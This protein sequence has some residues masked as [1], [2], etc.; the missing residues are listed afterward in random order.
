MAGSSV[1]RLVPVVMV[2]L[3][4]VGVVPTAVSAAA[5][6]PPALSVG[7]ASLVEGNSGSPVLR[8][9]V[10]LA[11]PAPG[12]VAVAYVTAPGTATAGRDYTSRQGTLKFAAGSTSAVVSVP[13]LPD[14]V[15]EPNETLTLRLSGATG[16]TVTRVVGTGRILDDDPVP[17]RQVGVGDVTVV[18]GATGTR[19]A[20]F[21]VTL[22][23]PKTSA[24]TVHYAT[25]DG[26]AVAGQDFTAVSG[27]LTIAAGQTSGDISV[28]ILGDV[29]AEPDE[30][31]DLV[32]SAP[33]G[34]A[35]GRSSAHG[36]IRNDDG[37]QSAPGA[38]LEP[39][40]VAGDGAVAA[41]WE[42]PAADGQSAVTGYRVRTSSDGGTTWSAPVDGDARTETIVGGLANGGAIRVQV[43]AV[44]AV[45]PGPWSVA[46]AAVTPNGATRFTQVDTGA[47]FTCAV[48]D[49]G[50]AECWG[51]NSSGQLGD[52]TTTAR[53]TPT[54]VL[55]LG[56][57][58]RAVSAGTFG[59]C[60][61]TYAHGVLCW[62]NLVADGSAA[63]RHHPVPVA[64][65]ASG[66]A[67]VTAGYGHACAFTDAGAARCWGSGGALGDGSLQSSLVPVPVSGLDHGVTDLD[68]ANGRT[69]AVADGTARCW[70]DGGYG[71]LGNGSFS[72]SLVPVTVGGLADPVADVATGAGHSCAA[73]TTGAVRCWGRNISGELGNGAT[74]TN[75]YTPVLAV[76]DGATAVSLH[77]ATSCALVAGALQC[78]GHDA[79]GLSLNMSLTTPVAESGLETGVAAMSSHG[80]A[81]CAFKSEELWCLGPNGDGELGDGTTQA[82]NVPVRV[83]RAMTP[84]AP[85]A[86]TAVPGSGAASLTWREPRGALPTAGYVA[87]SSD[88]LGGTWTEVSL[89]RVTTAQRLDG[90]T[91]GETYLVEVAATNTI[92]H[93]AWSDPVLVTPVPPT[94]AYTKVDAGG[95]STCGLTTAG[96]VRCWGASDDG[97]VGNGYP[98]R[99]D[100]APQT[101]AGIGPGALDVSAGGDHSCAVTAAGG[102]ACWGY[103][104]HGQLGDGTTDDSLVPV[105]VVGLAAPAA[106]VTAGDAF[107]C[108]R[109][110]DGRLQ[111]WGSNSDGQL[112]DGTTTESWTP[113]DVA[114]AA[115][116]TAVD[117]GTIHVCGR[118]ATGSARCWGSNAVG[119]LGVPA[120]PAKQTTPIEVTSLGSGV[121]SVVS[122][123]FHSCAV[124]DPG[125]LVCWGYNHHSQL[126]SAAGLVAPTPTAP[127]GLTGVVQGAAA[128]GEATCAIVDD[129]DVRCWGLAAVTG[130][131]GDAVAPVAVAGVHHGVAALTIGAG[132]ACVLDTAGAAAC[133]GD[134]ANGQLGDG[135]GPVALAPRPE[136]GAP[137]GLSGIEHGDGFACGLT[138]AHG[139]RCWGRNDFRQLGDGTD[140]DRAAPVDAVGLT[141]G[142]QQVSV[143]QRHACARRDDGSVWCWGDNTTGQLGLGS[144]RFRSVPTE[145]AAVGEP[146]TRIATGPGGTCAVLDSGTLSCWGQN[147][148][149]WTAAPVIGPGPV[150]VSTLPAPVADVSLSVFDTCA[151]LV[152]GGVACWGLNGYGQVGD[153]GSTDT[154]VPYLAVPEG[155]GATA[156]AISGVH[157]CAVV[158]AGAVRCWGSGAGL[159]GGAVAGNRSAAGPVA[160][161]AGPV[162]QVT[163]TDYASCALLVGAGDVQCWG[164][165]PA[166]QAGTG[167][168]SGTTGPVVVLEDV[169]ALERDTDGARQVAR[170]ADGASW[171]WGAGFDG[172]GRRDARQIAP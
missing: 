57:G 9:P 75:S 88:D 24:M 91:N 154:T 16:A 7:D 15:D 164:D 92:G 68:A 140:L 120:A 17:T 36:K 49:A 4:G 34:A 38:P 110:V 163:V 76:P 160:G 118:T 132:H 136:T 122:G 69:C 30:A 127:A 74:A 119:Q 41:R 150:V 83:L 139:V 153:G 33:S 105:A 171:W 61:L 1:R 166:G 113:V 125:A 35:L 109:L 133:W 25:A 39:E 12:A 134:D 20:R 115:T 53:P 151:V 82:R 167:T 56:A 143:S 116:Y 86:L 149:G 28:P 117:A 47:N 102:V 103:N 78:W 141:A 148:K 168:T 6:A 169:A 11:A 59:A 99:F 128:G 13:V 129:A 77:G 14:R 54:R 170:R 87:R 97:H 40:A 123:G 165:N 22:T 32:L 126:T 104:G 172:S 142:V 58:I 45:G 2:A 64:G 29:V 80:A 37:A 31:F 3:V 98:L 72:N 23:S 55:G 162:H 146:A 161:L 157:G 112:G 85:T 89:D 111:C 27:D 145:V 50:S 158:S 44:N 51:A 84:L 52:D 152:S 106:A 135:R 42:P 95:A 19:R 62:G 18:E 60:A 71:A 5:P 100:D 130:T 66:V 107:T 114:D 8:L 43:A 93:G 46:T 159:F 138:D 63:V 155:S 48:T 137:T 147:A 90:L 67:G 96:V 26:T 70:G 131:M 10:T 73:L 94:T 156:V 108:A 144:M 21:A 101:V 121:T 124:V 79:L 81:T 65:L